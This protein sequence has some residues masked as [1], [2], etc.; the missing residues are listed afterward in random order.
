ME[1]LVQQ[2]EHFRQAHVDAADW[3]RKTKLDVQ[4]F[5]DSNGERSALEEKQQKC[6]ELKDTFPDGEKLVDKA[7]RLSEVL[8][9]NITA[10]FLIANSNSR[11][12][13]TQ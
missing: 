13:S 12:I 8:G 11:L 3:I 6:C 9:F 1:Q 7:V 4:Q 2:H 5:G 10:L